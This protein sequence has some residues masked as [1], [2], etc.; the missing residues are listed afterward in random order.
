[1]EKQQKFWRLKSNNKFYLHILLHI[2][3]KRENS[4]KGLKLGKT[5][6]TALMSIKSS[7][8]QNFV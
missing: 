2:Q 8:I 3:K 7:S 6:Y 4:L 5:S 1:M